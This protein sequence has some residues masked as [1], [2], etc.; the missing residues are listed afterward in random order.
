M[1]EFEEKE[2]IK[3]R[4]IRKNTWYDSLINYIPKPLENWWVILT[5]KLILFK[6]NT[7][8]PM[9]VSNVK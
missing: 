3:K 7:T 5:K 4:P 1:G 9:C 2:M 8:K 6:S